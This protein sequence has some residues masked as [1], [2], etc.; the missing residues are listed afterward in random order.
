MK[1]EKHSTLTMEAKR[2]EIVWHSIA[3]VY[4]YPTRIAFSLKVIGAEYA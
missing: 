2:Y 4:C 3:H 1:Y